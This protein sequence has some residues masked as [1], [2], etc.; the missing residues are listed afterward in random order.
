M[1]NRYS[2]TLLAAALA[3]ASL[4]GCSTPRMGA[5]PAVDIESEEQA[6][7]VRVGKLLSRYEANDSAGVIAMLDPVSFTIWGSALGEV[8]DTPEE[9]RALMESDFRMWVTARFADVRD[10]DWRS[11]GTLATAN[12]VVSFSASGGQAIPIRLTTT[13]RKVEGDWRL[14]QAASSVP[15]GSG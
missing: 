15:T 1:R 7:R 4:P 5:A 9:L 13:W 2:A 3:S 6:L 10:F 14:T 8:V 12:F 11:D